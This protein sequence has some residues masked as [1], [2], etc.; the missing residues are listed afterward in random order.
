LQGGDVTF[1]CPGTFSVK[2]SGNAFVGPGSSPASLQALP[3]GHVSEQPN[4]IEVTHRD[5]DSEPFA[6]QGYKIHFEGGSALSGKL[7]ANGFAHHDNV[8]KVAQ[9]VEYEPRTPLKDAA[10]EPLDKLI[11]AAK[12]KLG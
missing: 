1:A 9:Y 10:W 4:W 2:G 3:T 7:D 5:A 6:G 12:N 11:E 8:P